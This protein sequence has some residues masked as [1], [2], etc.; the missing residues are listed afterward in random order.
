MSNQQT[1]GHL[2]LAE[3]SGENPCFSR[4]IW[5]WQHKI[6][7]KGEN[8]SAKSLPRP[9]LKERITVK[10]ISLPAAITLTEWSERTFFR[11]F[12]E[13]LL[14]RQTVNGKLMLPFDALKAHLCLALAPEELFVLEKADA[15]DAAA[16][17]ELALIF[18]ANNKPKGAIYWLELAA[19]QSN[20][21][22][23]SFL[24]QC[25]MQGNGLPKDENM[26]IMW[27]AKAAALG[28][29]IAQH[30]M[31]GMRAKIKEAQI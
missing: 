5:K 26:G 13:G 15:G 30:Q 28:H 23:M 10:R 8:G 27:L 19:R 17:N 7:A 18:L 21:E 31:Q 2:K 24:S 16:Q 14:S 6:V 12:A 3:K 11:K 25:Y 22:A 1:L 9:H 20:A 4:L 29:A